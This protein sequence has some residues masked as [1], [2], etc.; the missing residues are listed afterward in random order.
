M[1]KVILILFAALCLAAHA[2]TAQEMYEEVQ[3]TGIYSASQQNDS[4]VRVTAL[5][6]SWQKGGMGKMAKDVDRALDGIIKIAIRNLRHRGFSVEAADLER[7]WYPLKGETYRLF[8]AGQQRRITDYE[9]LSKYLAAAYFILEEKLGYE[10]CR[11]LHLDLILT[12]N[13][14]IKYCFSLLCQNPEQEFV[15]HFVGD[16]PTAF[17]PYRGLAPA[18]SY[19]LTA[20]TC[21]FATFGAGIFWLCGP[22]AMGVEFAMTKWGAPWL[23]PKIYGMACK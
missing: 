10:I 9:P 11:A 14:T 3:G 12:F 17:H 1:V 7:G 21:D 18:T 16:D 5:Q 4:S 22:L 23:E 6:N 15:W 8:Q 20:L 2:Q 13:Y 19:V